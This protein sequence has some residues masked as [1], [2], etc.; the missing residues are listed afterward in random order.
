MAKRFIG[1][2][3]H[4]WKVITHAGKELIVDSK[5]K[6]ARFDGYKDANGA[7]RKLGGVAV[8]V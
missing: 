7:A 5:G 8:R 6:P 2:D 4:D 3:V 1:K